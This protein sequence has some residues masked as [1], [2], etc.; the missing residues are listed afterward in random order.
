VVTS[1]LN[2]AKYLA[3]KDHEVMIFTTAKKRT[4]IPKMRITYLPSIDILR[5]PDFPIGVPSTQSLKVLAAFKP[6]IIHCH[7]PSFLGWEG[8]A[9]GKIKGIPVIG[10]YNTLLPEFLDHVKMPIKNAKLSKFPFAKSITW[11]YTKH[12]YNR[13]NTVITPSNAMKKELKRHG[14]TAPI[15]V[16]SNGVDTTL[17]YPRKVNKKRRT[18]LHVG[19]LSYE[20][21]IDI[22]IEAFK[23]IQETSSDTTL[24]IAGSGPQEKYLQD[25]AKYVKNIKFLGSVPHNKLPKLYSSAALFATASPI[26]TEGLVV[27]EAMACGL[28]IVGVNAGAIPDIVKDDSNGFIAPSNKPR[29]LADRITRIL[30]GTK[31]R[32][33]MEKSSLIAVKKY[34]IENTIRQLE[35]IYKE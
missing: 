19:R 3:K 16:V 20:K 30:K 24:V 33:K 2:A 7:M 35:K 6:D 18:I 8:L 22:L 15:R 13:C 14:I 27:L 23:T 4:T 10:T 26:E 21:R 12:F 1:I 31:L 5:Y 32:K 9:Y 25:F 28:P 29:M 34:A 11:N 17:F